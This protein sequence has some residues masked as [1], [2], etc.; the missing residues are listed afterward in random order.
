MASFP[1]VFLG[2]VLCELC[3]IS[4]YFIIIMVAMYISMLLSKQLQEA[5]LMYSRL[6]FCVVA[7]LQCFVLIERYGLISKSA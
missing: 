4:C 1:V 3:S 7:I 2:R 6:K 5:K